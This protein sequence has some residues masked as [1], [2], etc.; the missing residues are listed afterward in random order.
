MKLSFS[1]RGWG[2]L[3]WEELVESALDMR[4]SGIE[5][6]NLQKFPHLTGRGGPFH[7]HSVAAAV[8]QLRDQ[9]LTIPC[10]D[11]SMDISES[12]ANADVIMDVMRV[13]HD[14]HVPYV[15]GWASSEN[16]EM[17]C[18]NLERLLPLAEELDICLDRKSVV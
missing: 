16:E 14:A 10:F 17:I 5:V 12:A 13:A 8:R 7:K 2:D 4:F 11:T 6:Y 3:R 18:S 9:K 1:T 15:V